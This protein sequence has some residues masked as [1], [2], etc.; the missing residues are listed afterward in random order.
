MS[1]YKE[2]LYEHREKTGETITVEEELILLRTKTKEQELRINELEKLAKTGHG[3]LLS[4][5]QA[6]GDFFFKE[7]FN[8]YAWRDLDTMASRFVIV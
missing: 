5:C 6:L 8:L 1:G 3:F 4:V 7:E 2:A